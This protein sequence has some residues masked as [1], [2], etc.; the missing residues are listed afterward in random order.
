MPLLAPGQR[1]L[2]V[3]VTTL[4]YKKYVPRPPN[5]STCTAPECSKPFFAKRL[6]KRHYERFRKFHRLHNINT[7]LDLSDPDRVMGWIKKNVAITEN[8]CWEWQRSL[9]RG[10]AVLRIKY[11]LYRGIRVVAHIH[12]GM[13]LDSALF[14]C[15]K[16]DNRKCLN[17]DHLFLGTN[18]DN[19]LDAKQKGRTAR[20]SGHGSA[21][22]TEEQ[23]VAIRLMHREGATL[24]ELSRQFGIGSA[25]LH[26]IVNRKLWQ[27]IS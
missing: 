14:V 12:H 11:K 24:V 9:A 19:I 5:F 7:S 25:G 26:A 6:C 4:V 23:V 16:C 3:S 1:N 27:H 15:H 21:K 10:Y 2:L 22:L 18:K 20:G 8:R 17:P 13:P